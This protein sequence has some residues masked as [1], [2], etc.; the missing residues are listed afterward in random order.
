MTMASSTAA[1]HLDERLGKLRTER[2]ETIRL[3]EVGA[4]V[5]A[6]LPSGSAAG[7]G[8]AV[9][10]RDLREMVETVGRA[11]EDLAALCPRR[12]AAHEL[13]GARDELEAV[14]ANTAE[15]AG[16]FMDVAERMGSL[17]GNLADEQGEVLAGLSTEIF[18]AS[19][20]QDITGQRVNKVLGVLRA[21]EAR[22]T[23]L[24]DL[25]GDEYVGEA[26]PEAFDERG[27][28]VDAEALKHGPQLEGQGNSQADIDALLA[29]FD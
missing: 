3:E 23:A 18:E 15:A 2:G 11:K 7:E 27:E 20:F 16:R 12:M 6:I 5:A 17:A 19:S 24:A 4:T 29:S 1:R 14:I 28:V 21:V 10:G 8:I 25:I 22:L 13:P 9:L 26:D